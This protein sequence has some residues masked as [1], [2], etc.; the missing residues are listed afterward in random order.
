MTK[1]INP[2]K[3]D[4]FSTSRISQCVNQGV[5]LICLLRA[6]PKYNNMFSLNQERCMFGH[7]IDFWNYKGNST[8]NLRVLQYRKR[9]IQVFISHQLVPLP[10]EWRR[11]TVP[12]IPAD[13]LRLRRWQRLTLM[14]SATPGPQC[15]AQWSIL[16]LAKTWNECPIGKTRSWPK[17]L[18]KAWNTTNW[19]W[20]T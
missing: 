13:R 11:L 6:G 17:C 18:P 1:K 19:T 9:E 5:I 7:K 16:T 15:R 12:E 8:A 14:E 20:K 10:R 3:R 4:G 2:Q